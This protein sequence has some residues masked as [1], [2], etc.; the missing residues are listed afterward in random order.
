MP[1]K[2][3]GRLFR[4]AIFRD[5]EDLVKQ[6]GYEEFAERI[7]LTG[8]HEKISNSHFYPPQSTNNKT[9]VGCKTPR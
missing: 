6:T 3:Q 8:T 1:K 2:G 5:N 7:Y 4:T 9:Y